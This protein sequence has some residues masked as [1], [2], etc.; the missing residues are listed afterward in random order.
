MSMAYYNHHQLSTNYLTKEG[1]KSGIK[2]A[3]KKR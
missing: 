1:G 2:V 3:K